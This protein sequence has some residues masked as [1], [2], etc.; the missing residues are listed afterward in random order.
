RRQVDVLDQLLLE[1]LLR[2]FPRV[3][4]QRGDAHRG[5]VAVAAR[6]ELAAGGEI[7]ECLRNRA[8]VA[9]GILVPPLHSRVDVGE[10]RV[11]V[12]HAKP[13]R[14]TGKRGR[15]LRIE[16]EALQRKVATELE[17]RFFFDEMAFLKLGLEVLERNRLARLQAEE[18]RLLPVREYDL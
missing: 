10:G 18:R 7:D 11:P 9:P 12:A 5:R 8:G 6:P 13:V 3:L 4:A 15:E 14:D 17:L 2:L 1:V 16:D